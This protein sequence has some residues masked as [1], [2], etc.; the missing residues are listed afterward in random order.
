M[1]PERPR[2]PRGA[3]PRVASVALAA[4]GALLLGACGGQNDDA[5]SP[6]SPPD[7]GTDTAATASTPPPRTVSPT[8]K[9]EPAGTVPAPDPAPTSTPAPDPTPTSA[10]PPAQRPAAPARC[11]ADHLALSLGRID[12]GAGQRHAPLVFTNTGSTTCALR[13][14]PGVSLL[15]SSGDRVG[16][17]A[18]RA[19]S[20]LPPVELDPGESAFASLHT[21]GRG[22][23]D[24]PCWPRADQVQA[25]PPGSTRALRTP[26]APF[27]VCGDTFDVSAV[28]PGR[29]P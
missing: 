2:T 20:M 13:G 12:A 27:E 6:P 7:R 19:G 14:Y 15:D 26:A 25:Y 3:R 8:G 5:S 17:P 29:H 24:K 16:R 18:R 23:T 9:A 4:A 11:T 22:V 21:V 28:E 10:P 1:M